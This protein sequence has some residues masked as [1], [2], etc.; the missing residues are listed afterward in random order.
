[1]WS[2]YSDSERVYLY[3]PTFRK[4]LV[5]WVNIIHVDLC[6]NWSENWST[7]SF[8]VVANTMCCKRR[9]HVCIVTLGLSASKHVAVKCYIL[10]QRGGLPLH[11]LCDSIFLCFHIQ[12]RLCSLSYLEFRGLL[13]AYIAIANWFAR[14]CLVSQWRPNGHQICCHPSFTLN[15][16]CWKRRSNSAGFAFSSCYW[17]IVPPYHIL[18]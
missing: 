1:M 18:F 6:T 3:T 10:Y 12:I 9:G 15:L 7:D 13:C 17:V 16:I 5:T 8:A 11:R 4:R 2:N 14:A